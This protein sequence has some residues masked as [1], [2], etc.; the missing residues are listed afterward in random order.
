LLIGYQV[1][2]TLDQHTRPWHK[3]RDGTVYYKNPGP[4]QKGMAQMPN[5]PDEAADPRERPPGTPHTAWNC[6]CY[7]T[8]VLRP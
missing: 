5:P 3:Q 4:G 7:L 8:P 2:A 1:H 6:R